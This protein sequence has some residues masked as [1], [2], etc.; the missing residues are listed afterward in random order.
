M[1]VRGVFTCHIVSAVAG[2]RVKR[3]E[4]VSLMV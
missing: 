4:A 3:N 2:E 1:C